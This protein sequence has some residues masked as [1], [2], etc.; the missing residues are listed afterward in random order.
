MKNFIIF[1]ILLLPLYS[2]GENDTTK[3]KIYKLKYDST[4]L[5]NES[6]VKITYLSPE[7]K[8]TKPKDL[9][10]IIG[11][12]TLCYNSISN[13]DTVM[14]IN[15]GEQIF[16]V[17]SKWWQSKITKI[18]LEGNT[19]SNIEVSFGEKILSLPSIEY[20]YNKPVIY[21]YPKNELDVEVKLDLKGTLNFTY[22]KYE[23]GWNFKAFPNGDLLIDQEKYG[24]LF[25]EGRVLA[26]NS[27][28]DQSEGFLVSSENLLGFFENMLSKM[29]L[30]SKEKQD[31]ITYWYPLMK[32]NKTNFIHFIFNEN[33]NRIASLEVNPKPDN[34]IRLFMF[35]QEVSDNN[36]ITIKEQNI[37]QYSRE[38]FTVVEWGGAEIPENTLSFTK[39]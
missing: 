29:G 37:P 1:T 5:S 4:L 2:F 24:Y 12:D 10:L 11:K 3:V 28:F 31:F 26:E 20:D 25:W 39:E 21:F 33:Y 15:S 30:N 18:N 9:V 34:M 13:I 16:E 17:R 8:A 6:L 14:K 35:W 7:Q 22:P 32:D 27:S 36:V 38:G 19:F 23:N